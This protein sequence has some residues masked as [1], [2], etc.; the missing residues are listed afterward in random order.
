MENRSRARCHKFFRRLIA[1]SQPEQIPEIM[2]TYSDQHKAL[3]ENYLDIVVNSGGSVSYQDIV[4][5]EL[6][7]IHM[8]VVSLNKR[9]EAMSGKKPTQML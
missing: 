7:L 3:E 4:Q 9:A 2:K 1:T 5:M 8:L 6:P